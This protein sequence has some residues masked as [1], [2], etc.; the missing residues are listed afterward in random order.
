MKLRGTTGFPVQGNL[1]HSLARQ[2]TDWLVADSKASAG[3]PEDGRELWKAMYDRF[4]AVRLE[5]LI[6]QGLLHRPTICP[7][8]WRAFVAGS[9]Y[10]RKT[11]GADFR[12][13]RD[14]FM[15]QEPS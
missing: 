14:L 10:Y 12:S 5:E 13:W 3:R 15:T 6:R 9:G 4:A 7:A 11:A 8:R 1:F 2:F